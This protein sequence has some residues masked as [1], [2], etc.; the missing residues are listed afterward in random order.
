MRRNAKKRLLPLVFA[1]VLTLLGTALAVP[2]IGITVQKV[3]AGTTDTVAIDTTKAAVN[4]EF[5][6]LVI[7]GATITLDKGPGVDG[8]WTFYVTLENGTVI[9]KTGSITSDQTTITVSGLNIDLEDTYI[10]KVS[11]VIAGKQVSVS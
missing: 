1:L 4:W 2:K 9:S 5:S 10:T 8:N 6:G 11:L 7:T 3:G